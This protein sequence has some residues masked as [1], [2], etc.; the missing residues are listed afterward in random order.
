MPGIYYFAEAVRAA[1]QKPAEVQATPAIKRE[2]TNSNQVDVDRRQA[3]EGPRFH[4]WHDPSE[5]EDVVEDLWTRGE[6]VTVELP[7]FF[8]SFMAG[9]P[10]VNRHYEHVRKA[11]E[12]WI[13]DCA[14]FSPRYRKAVHACNFSLF[15]S[16][17]APDAKE[18]ELRTMCDW[19][20]WV[21]PYDDS[22]FCSRLW[23][24]ANSKTGQ[25]STMASSKT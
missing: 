19:G 8:V 17:A 4:I 16:I 11:S 5:N 10:E 22:K 15:M 18:D 20:N 21:F 6:K 1:G 3:K 2:P 7:D 14:A 24:W 25:C 13:S 9:K 12:R 23:R